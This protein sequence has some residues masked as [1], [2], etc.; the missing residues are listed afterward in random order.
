LPEAVSEHPSSR[1][2]HVVD[3]VSEADGAWF[4]AH[5]A[6]VE[7]LRLFVRG[8]APFVDEELVK[9][10]RHVPAG[11]AA[12]ALIRVTQLQPGLRVRQVRIVAAPLDDLPPDWRAVVRDGMLPPQEWEA[13]R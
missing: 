9:A 13:G 8:E 10:A 2:A 6:E 11:C 3:L 7:Y 1:S 5:P 4:E 12:A